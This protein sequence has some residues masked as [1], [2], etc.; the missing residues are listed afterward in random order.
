VP[1][2]D[3]HVFVQPTSVTRSTSSSVVAPARTCRRPSSRRDG[4]PGTMKT[5]RVQSADHWRAW[6]EE[7]H[8]SESE[9]WLVFYKRHTGDTSIDY[10]DALDEALCFGWVD[11]LIKRLDDRRYARKFTP[12]RADSRWS[13]A[14]RK[15]YAELKAARRL[16]PAGIKRPP[17]DRGY[18]PRPARRPMPA[19][20]PRYFQA[21]LQEHAAA[22]RT[23]QALTPAQRRRYLAWIESARR[24]E[25]RM[26][27]LK[28]ALRLLT[29]GKALGLK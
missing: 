3:C 22:R 26:R 6:L 25:T 28:E 8:A 4:A 18:D 7:H 29:G 12:R 14:N 11:S 24:E 17:T 13:G 20:L 21:A 23:F 2:P 16:Q 15:R 10:K 9:V 19:R 27:R 1:Q 5:L